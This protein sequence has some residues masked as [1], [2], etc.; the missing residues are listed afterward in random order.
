MNTLGE[1]PIPRPIRLA[2][3]FLGVII[4]GTLLILYLEETQEKT[5]NIPTQIITPTQTKNISTERRIGKDNIETIT[6]VKENTLKDPESLHDNVFAYT[7]D[8][9]YVSFTMPNNWTL[10]WN[11]VKDPGLYE[12]M[13]IE[14]G[15][16]FITKGDYSLK[17]S[18]YSADFNSGCY[19]PDH[20]NF[21]R[22]DEEFH[23]L[24]YPIKIKVFK[25]ILTSSHMVLRRGVVINQK[26]QDTPQLIKELVC[27]KPKSYQAYDYEKETIINQYFAHYIGIDYFHP[28]NPDSK[29]IK[30]MDQ[31]LESLSIIVAPAP[32]I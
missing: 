4:I 7:Q 20:Q 24:F 22:P 28:K 9:S 15:D 1:K 13:A 2:L 6:V 25:E 26:N 11:E 27:L 18:P 10:T 32:K 31:I 30:T 12:G 5:S 16:I 14:S 19:F 29:M 3:V 23:P 21:F 17:I 8:G